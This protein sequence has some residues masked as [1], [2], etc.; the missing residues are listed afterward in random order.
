MDPE[1]GE[2]VVIKKDSIHV[3]DMKIQNGKVFMPDGKVY[4]MDKT[5]VTP[6][7]PGARVEPR[8]PPINMQRLTPEQRRKL[9]LLKEKFP[10][11]FPGPVPPPSPKPQ[12]KATNQ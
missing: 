6:M 11:A 5:P 8:M 12:A 10:E 9:R 4:Q 3:G 2:K 7:Q 1:D